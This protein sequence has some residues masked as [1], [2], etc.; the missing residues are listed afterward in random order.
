MSVLLGKPL[1]VIGM[2]L[3]NHEKGNI[4]DIYVPRIENS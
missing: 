3:G 1:G 2:Y 4:I